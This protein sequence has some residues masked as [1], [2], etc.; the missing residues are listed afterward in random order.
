M[1]IA[2][3]S[4]CLA[5]SLMSGVMSGCRVQGG[6]GWTLDRCDVLG[7]CLWVLGG[8]GGYWLDVMYWV[9]VGVHWVGVGGHWIDVMYW[10]IVGGY[11]VGVGGHWIA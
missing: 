3:V 6:C 2:A 5:P 10:M 9:D 11:W 4:Q 8:W 7:G 1:T